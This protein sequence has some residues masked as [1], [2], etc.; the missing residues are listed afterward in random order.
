MDTEQIIRAT[1]DVAAASS[2][3]A[4]LFGL[5]PAIAGIFG[6]VWYGI[7]IW[8]SKTVQHAGKRWRERRVR[9]D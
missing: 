3:L 8:E 5:M 9:K 6:I 7:Q 2:V 4:A 1:G